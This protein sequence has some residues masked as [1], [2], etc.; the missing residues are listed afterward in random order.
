[1]T[2]NRKTTHK[3]LWVLVAIVAATAAYFI[4]HD[5]QDRQEEDPMQ[6]L[7]RQMRAAQLREK[8]LRIL[9]GK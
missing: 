1:M 9:E 5:F 6:V 3:P 8:S 2:D 4:W 7:S